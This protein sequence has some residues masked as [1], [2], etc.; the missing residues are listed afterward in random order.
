MQGKGTEA[1][2]DFH[3]S[4]EL[5]SKLKQEIDRIVKEIKKADKSQ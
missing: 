4:L 1:E 2:E 5:D 3:K